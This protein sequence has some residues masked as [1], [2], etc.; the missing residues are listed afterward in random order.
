ME[1]ELSRG[2][3]TLIDD[4]DFERVSKHKWYSHDTKSGFYAATNIARKCVYLHTFLMCSPKGKEVDHIN[5]NKLDNRKEN[6]RLVT[7][8]QNSFNSESRKELPKG[9]C[10]DKQTGKYIAQI[11]YNGK[12]IKIGRFKTILEASQEYDKKAHILFGEYA[13]LEN[14]EVKYAI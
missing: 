10:F 13:R 11:M 4:E 8:Q 2:L 12:N 6:L 7:H 1:I 14:M 9:V 3:K 5:G